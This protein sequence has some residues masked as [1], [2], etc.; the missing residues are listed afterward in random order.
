MNFNEELRTV[1]QEEARNLSAPLELKEQILNRA[2]A[3]QGGRRMK[4]W[5]V[6][7]IMAAALL[8]P[9]GAYAGYHYLADNMY[10]SPATAATIGVTQ[11]QYDRLEDK[12]QNAKQSFDEEEF[13]KLMSL[14]EELGSY[15]LQ[16]ADAEGVF[17]LEQLGA[18]DQKAYKELQAKIEPYFEQIN[19]AKTSKKSVQS[20]DRD[21]FW[22][23]LLEKAEQRLTKKEFE[24][25]ERLIIDLQSYDAKVFDADGSVHM[26]RLSKEEIQNQ[27]KLIE[28][29]D[30]Y[31][32]KLDMMIKPSS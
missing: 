31:I 32:K 6:A 10:G 20:V 5:L 25:I 12:L 17:H 16:M 22:N 18:K 19:E 4:K 14:L 21:A 9:T 30:P 15:N 29:L 1:L 23:G 7:S 24:E 26:D 8:I 13:T 27:E 28:A 2:V 3:K 11:Q